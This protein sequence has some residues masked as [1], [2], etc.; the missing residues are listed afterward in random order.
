MAAMQD[1][2]GFSCAIQLSERLDRVEFCT[3][4]GGFLC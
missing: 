4:G 3:E 1:E 2:G